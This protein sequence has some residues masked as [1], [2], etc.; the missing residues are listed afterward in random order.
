MNLVYRCDGEATILV[1]KNEVHIT[2]MRNG[3]SAMD[4]AV[5]NKASVKFTIH[6]YN[7]DGDKM[8]RNLTSE[9]D[10]L[11]VDIK[12][13][14]FFRRFRQYTCW[15]TFVHFNISHWYFWRLHRAVARMDD[16]LIERLVKPKPHR[17]A[18]EGIAR[19]GFSYRL[20]HEYQFEAM[21]RILSSQ[22]DA[23]YLLL[24]PFGTGKTYVLAAAVER[25]L[26]IPATKIL[27]C[28]HQNIGADKL[29]RSLQEHVRGIH[30]NV[31]RLVPDRAGLNRNSDLLH[32]YSCKAVREVGVQELVEWR[33]IVTT[34]LTALSVKDKLIKERSYLQFTHII[35]DEG[36]QSREPEA[37]GALVLADRNTKVLVA[38]DHQQV[39]RTC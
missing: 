20:D 10:S 19:K 13:K 18:S 30:T 11:T 27:V 31:L 25:L 1:G 26:K 17:F 6:G 7:Y 28:T 23:P 24:G 21:K 33:V 35:I 39:Q 22:S 12:Q 15:K 37:L 14:G 3:S 8:F 38:G 4:Y 5:Q 29:Y 16:W 32:P 36:A 9:R 34:F 2:E